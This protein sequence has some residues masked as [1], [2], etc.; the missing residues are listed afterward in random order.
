MSKKGK[1]KGNSMCDPYCMTD[2]IT[3]Y[4]VSQSYEINT[5]KCIALQKCTINLFN[6]NKIKPDKCFESWITFLIFIETYSEHKNDKL[7]WSI[8]YF[9]D[10]KKYI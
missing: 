10:F 7:K 1:I 9:R 4:L 8:N 5:N 2:W 6:W 3:I